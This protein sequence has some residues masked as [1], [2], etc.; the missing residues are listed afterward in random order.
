MSVG[1]GLVNSVLLGSVLAVGVYVGDHLL[2]RLLVVPRLDAWH[3]VPFYWWLLVLSPGVLAGVVV[4][5]VSDSFRGVIRSAAF[6]G[7]MVA[8]YLLWAAYTHQPGQRKVGVIE[9]PIGFWAESTVAVAATFSALS[10]LALLA[11]RA[12]ENARLK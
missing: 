1:H 8:L 6:G 12:Q 10:S 9:S 4:G 5:V 7:A 3:S 2:Y 11:R